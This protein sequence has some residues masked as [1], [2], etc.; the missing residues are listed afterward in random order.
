MGQSALLIIDMQK[1]FALPGAPLFVD[2]APEVLPNIVR[3]RTAARTTSMPVVHVIRNYRADGSDVEITR[4]EKFCAC[5]GACV[6]G[7]KGAEILEELAPEKG[8]HLIIKPRWSAFFHTDLDKLL[9]SL[10]VDQ[11]VLAG[12]Q[13]PNCIRATAWDANSLDY[14]VVVLT[15]ATGAKTEAVHRANLLDMKNIGIKLMSTDEF[16]A[17]APDIPKEGYVARIRASVDARK[18]A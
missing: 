6:P 15:D 9:A 5:G 1:D 3:A 4:Y 18:G 10:D 16:C 8:E 11:V 7:T 17:S 2:S 14:E 13:T 12:V